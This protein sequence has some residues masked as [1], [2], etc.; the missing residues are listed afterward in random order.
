MKG[1]STV[2]SPNDL[3]NVLTVTLD[4]K[5]PLTL[6]VLNRRLTMVECHDNATFYDYL[7]VED[8]TISPELRHTKARLILH[9]FS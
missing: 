2:L 1:V 8:P 6:F 5:E 4:V 7:K 9:W 3:A